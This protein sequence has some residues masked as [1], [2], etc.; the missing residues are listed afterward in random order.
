MSIKSTD[1]DQSEFENRIAPTCKRLSGEIQQLTELRRL[2]GGA[3]MESWLVVYGASQWVLRRLPERMEGLSED[4]DASAG[5]DIETEAYVIDIAIR[6]GVTAPEIVG[7]LQPSDGLGTGFVMKRI[8]GE[9]LPHKILKEAQYSSARDNFTRQCARELA[10]IHAIPLNEL[11]SD[12]PEYSA[13][14]IIETLAQR[15]ADYDTLIPI[16]DM[17]LYWLNENIPEMHAPAFV[18]GDFR[19]GNLMVDDDGIAAVLDWEQGHIGDPARDLAYLCTPSWRFGHYDKPVG[20]MGQ[21]QDLIQHY[22]E[23]SDVTVPLSDIRFWMILSSLTWGLGTQKMINLWRTGKDRSLER[24]VIGRRTSE[25]E[26]DLLLML[27]DALEIETDPMQW[28]LPQPKQVTGKTHASEM[29]QALV[30]WDEKSV[31][32]DADG[33]ELFQARVARNA[34]GILTREVN[35]GPECLDA[36]ARRL[37]KLNVTEAEV[38][39]RLGNGALTEDLLTHLRIDILDRL[40]IDQPGYAGLQ[41]AKDKWVAE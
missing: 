2:T 22:R 29:L 28:A 35:F 8:M 12:V 19:L 6:N 37:K 23:F 17:A 5:I 7:L 26:I 11:P 21:I 41:A 20:G 31:M 33:R 39:N 4:A 24:A 1:S 25:T 3:N 38:C 34:M 9:T 14:T 36:T 13:S 32:P 30:E 16:F 15:Y 27:E 10:K 40:S 18:H